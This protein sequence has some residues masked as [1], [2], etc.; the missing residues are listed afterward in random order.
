M[1]ENFADLIGG[2]GILAVVG[3]VAV[4]EEPGIAAID[5]ESRVGLD[6]VHHAEDFPDFNVQ[7]SLSAEKDVAVGVGRLIAIIHQFGIFADLFVV[8]LDEFEEPQ[9]GPL[10]HYAE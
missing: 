4:K 10:R 1:D 9:H 8:A 5:C 6:F 2:V 7:C 3:V